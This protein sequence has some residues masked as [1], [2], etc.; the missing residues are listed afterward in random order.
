[1]LHRVRHTLARRLSC[2]AVYF[3]IFSRSR[4]SR[5]A[6]ISAGARGVLRTPCC[7]HHGLLL[8]PSKL[9]V[10]ADRELAYHDRWQYSSSSHVQLDC[11]PLSTAPK[12]ATTTNNS[13]M[14]GGVAMTDPLQ[15]TSLACCQFARREINRSVWTK[16]V[17][18]YLVNLPSS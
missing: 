8:S 17:T 4:C 12:S 10:S 15:L 14:K 9:S 2:S 5:S 16:R 3:A 13:T 11:L 7:L 18:Y 1:M 6:I